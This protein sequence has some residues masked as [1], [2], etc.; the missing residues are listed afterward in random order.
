MTSQPPARPPP[1]AVRD[2]ENSNLTANRFLGGSVRKPWMAPDAS[3]ALPSKPA[4]S[5]ARPRQQ[6]RSSSKITSTDPPSQPLPP[7]PASSAAPPP[8]SA[9]ESSPPS[10]LPAR[11]Q[12]QACDA[13][14]TAA[15]AGGTPSVTPA[16]PP[17]PDPGQ[18]PPFDTSPHAPFWHKAKEQLNQ[19]RTQ[20]P[21]ADLIERPRVQILQEACEHRDLDFLALHQ[22]YCLDSWSPDEV[23]SLTEPNS[24]RVGLAVIVQLLVDNQRMSRRLLERLAAFP[25]PWG[26]LSNRSPYKES[27]ARVG[28]MLERWSHAWAQFEQEVVARGYPPLVDDLVMKL[29]VSSPVL[30]STIFTASVRRLYGSHRDSLVRACT[31]LFLE[32]QNRMRARW[33]S[34]TSIPELARKAERDALITRFRELVRQH[35]NPAQGQNPWPVRPPGMSS[36]AATTL[37]HEAM[38][39]TAHAR[40]PM[41]GAMPSSRP[42][43]T[44]TPSPT[45]PQQQQTRMARSQTQQQQWAPGVSSGAD[46]PG[47][48]QTS[49]PNG[50]L[51]QGA[52]VATLTNGVRPP[53]SVA[54][55]QS[56]AYTT[57]SPSGAMYSPVGLPS[58]GHQSPAVMVPNGSQSTQPNQGQHNLPPR[59][60]PLQPSGRQPLPP[61]PQPLQTT[62]PQTLTPGPLPAPVSRPQPSP[63]TAGP[64]PSPTARSQPATAQSTSLLPPGGQRTPPRPKNP[65]WATLHLDE[66]QRSSIASEPAKPDGPCL[67]KYVRTFALQPVALP[68]GESAFK[69][70]LQISPDFIERRP[71]V[72]RNANGRPVQRLVPGVVSLRLR[73][74]PCKEGADLSDMSAW[75]NAEHKWP[76]V[77]YVHLNSREFYVCRA[78]HHGKDLPL[79]ITEHLQEGTNILSLHIIRNQEE[80]QRSQ[81]W[82]I[83]VEVMTVTT[84]A[85]AKQMAK[86]LPASTARSLIRSR[87]ARTPRPQNGNNNDDDD[88]DVVVVGDDI[89]IDMQDPFSR[90]PIKVPARGASCKHFE[91][92]DLDTFLETVALG[93]GVVKRPPY[94]RCP[95]CRADAR[96]TNLVIDEFFVHV[97]EELRTRQ[98]LHRTAAIR[99]KADASWEP[100]F[101][102]DDSSG[103]RSRPGSDDPG[104]SRKRSREEFEA[105]GHGEEIKRPPKQIEVIELD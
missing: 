91:C 105:D 102:D 64:Q 88:E 87:L 86:R 30:Q 29:D 37:P 66:R 25:E 95:I 104:T 94:Q 99:V 71:R 7:K 40:P 33:G 13:S 6:R 76:S 62:R 54:V 60:P 31:N 59:P 43:Y 79:D 63:T 90:Q 80:R 97:I 56:L 27:I 16:G 8:T 81:T 52:P 98:V 89:R 39:P 35:P 26:A 24:R 57:I 83:G 19:L 84:V 101:R 21:L 72:E 70:R 34:K 68:L 14:T 41:L 36:V 96:P 78:F 67:I 48:R 3:V 58:N 9:S 10:P 50:Y 2:V 82:A 15:A 45:F 92:F 100:E 46:R 53:V 73:C 23:R 28:H 11:T 85:D 22:V 51:A 18:L 17:P 12:E 32:D 5:A 75:S 65:A 49:Q 38:A 55:S 42:F 69:W 44:G 20:L 1:T 47:V 74:V 4:A 103:L 93:P 61:R 77:I